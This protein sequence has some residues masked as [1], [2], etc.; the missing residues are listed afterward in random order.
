MPAMNGTTRRLLGVIVGL[1]VIVGVLTVETNVQR[2]RTPYAEMWALRLP[3]GYELN[4]Q[5]IT[6]RHGGPAGWAL[7]W[8]APDGVSTKLAGR[9]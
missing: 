8:Y 5:S 6:S 4:Y 3:L 7:F 1:T 9:P 2:F